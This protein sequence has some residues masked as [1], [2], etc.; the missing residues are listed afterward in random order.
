MKNIKLGLAISKKI[1]IN[2]KVVTMFIDVCNQKNIETTFVEDVTNLDVDALV[3]FGGDGTLLHF[4]TRVSPNTPIFG[5]N[6]GNLGFLT[7]IDSTLDSINNC[8]DKLVKND[9]AIVPHCLL[10]LEY[11]INGE[12]KSFRAINDL[13]LS[14]IGRSK[15]VEIDAVIANNNLSL[16][17][18]GIIIATP[19]GSSAYSIVCGGSI[20]LN[21]AN[22]FILTPIGNRYCPIVYNNDNSV[23]LTPKNDKIELYLDGNQIKDY[24]GQEIL[25]KKATEPCNFITFNDS[26]FVKLSK[27]LSSGF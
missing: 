19:T 23:I 6:M 1:D 13:V 15:T 14:G 25:V 9:Y 17:G 12:K 21:D 20:L 27:R 22:A 10:Q 7:Q 8:L 26:F 16:I 5:V 3:T 18:D 24:F 2:D 11:E 4:A